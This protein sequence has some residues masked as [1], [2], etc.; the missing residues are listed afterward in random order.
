MDADSACEEDEDYRMSEELNEDDGQSGVSE[1]S[2][3]DDNWTPAG[4]RK[5]AKKG[6]RRRK[7]RGTALSLDD[8]ADFSKFDLCAKQRSKV[9]SAYI[10]NRFIEQQIALMWC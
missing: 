8:V 10:Y 5:P 7:T 9:V 1:A 2:F 4:G 3:S 6:G